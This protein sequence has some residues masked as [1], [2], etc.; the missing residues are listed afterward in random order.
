MYF[1]KSLGNIYKPAGGC[2]S[3]K[4]VSSKFSYH[5]HWSKLFLIAELIYLSLIWCEAPWQPLCVYFAVVIR[6]SSSFFFK[7]WTLWW[8]FGPLLLTIRR[9]VSLGVKSKSSKSQSTFPS[10]PQLVSHL[11]IPALLLP[12]RWAVSQLALLCLCG[13]VLVNK[14]GTSRW[15]LWRRVASGAQ[16][17]LTWK[18]KAL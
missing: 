18:S 1:I 3:T 4:S 13:R 16:C 10:L 2:E 14:R 6:C 8:F 17:W 5:T 9:S 12:L 11:L 15:K 7:I